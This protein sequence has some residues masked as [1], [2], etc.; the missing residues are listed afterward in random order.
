MKSWTVPCKKAKSSVKLFKGSRPRLFGSLRLCVKRSDLP[1]R[2]GLV[3]PREKGLMVVVVMVV[4]V[5]VGAVDAPVVVV[6]RLV[7]VVVMVVVLVLLVVHLG[8]KA[9]PPVVK[10]AREEK[11]VRIRFPPLLPLHGPT[12][13]QNSTLGAHNSA[14]ISMFMELA[15]KARL[16]LAVT[17]VHTSP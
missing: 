7:V 8:E 12:F 3:P 10:G 13:G 16:A 14:V 2:I 6:V 1:T 15:Q 17:S 11:G 9:V 5:V 4:V